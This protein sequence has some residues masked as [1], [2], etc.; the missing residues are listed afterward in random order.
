MCFGAASMTSSRSSVRNRWRRVSLLQ[1]LRAGL[2]H[3]PVPA[4][5][6]GDL[7]SEQRAVVTAETDGPIEILHIDDG[8][9]NVVTHAL[10][11]ELHAHLDRI[12]ANRDSKAV[13]IA[14][15]A[16]QFSGGFDLKVMTT[17][18]E[19]CRDLVIAGG[20]FCNRLLVFPRITIAA[21]TGNAIAEGAFIAS[22]CDW[23]VGAEGAFKI[24][25]P[26]TAIGMSIPRFGIEIARFRLNTSYFA[27]AT[28]F[29]E[30]FNPI[31]AQRAGFV[32][33]IVPID[34]VVD[35]AKAK[36]HELMPLDAAAV[37]LTKRKARHDLH[38]LIGS[39]IVDDVTSLTTGAATAATAATAVTGAAGAT[40]SP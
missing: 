21:A 23:V 34:Q 19:A 37:A 26:E 15:R 18:L 33:E 20:Q 10:L 3:A 14:G 31:D 12:E 13:I 27:R 39:T 2:E 8:K 7:V 17:S 16:G 1:Q 25:L 4:F 11:D 38:E 9:A 32:D 6:W 40:A 28:L 5:H 35:R 36:A 22:S 29:A 30:I 24:G